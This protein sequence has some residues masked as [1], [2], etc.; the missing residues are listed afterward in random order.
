MAFIGESKA[1]TINP[2]DQFIRKQLKVSGSWY[3]PIWMYNE[4]ARFIVSK[5]LPL[6]DLVTHHFKIE[7]AQMA[8]DIFDKRETGAVIFI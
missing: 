4:I 7:D 8:Y 1:T 2:S 6:E 5:K 3:F